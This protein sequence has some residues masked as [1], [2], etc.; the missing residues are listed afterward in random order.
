MHD[1]II[2]NSHYVWVFNLGAEAKLPC[3]RMGGNPS[4]K[5]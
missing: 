5:R 1:V 2:K 3:A 4:A